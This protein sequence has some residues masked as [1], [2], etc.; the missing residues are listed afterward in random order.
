[1]SHVCFPDTHGA[2]HIPS[3]TARLVRLGWKATQCL[4]LLVA[5]EIAIS[6][7][8][9]FTEADLA[10][11]L[12]VASFLGL[13]HLDISRFHGQTVAGEPATLGHWRDYAVVALLFSLGLWL[14][15]HGLAM[16]AESV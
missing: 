3:L 5:A 6:R 9:F 2:R 14:L 7:Q 12:T 11:W 16:L 1:M 15:A 10:F 13:R 8:G 4:V